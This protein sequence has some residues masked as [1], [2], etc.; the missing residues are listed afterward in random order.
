MELRDR[1]LRNIRA[2]RCGSKTSLSISSYLPELRHFD[3][4]IENASPTSAEFLFADHSPRSVREMLSIPDTGQIRILLAREAVSPDF[5][6]FDYAISFDSS[7]ESGRH[8]RPH[9]LLTFATDARLLATRR[10]RHESVNSFATRVGFCDFI[11]G[12]SRAHPM[13]E[14][15]L[16][17]L[18]RRFSGVETMRK[19]KGRNW[20]AKKRDSA[21]VPSPNWRVEK[22]SLQENF[23][24]SIAAENAVFP[25]YTT[26]KLL[27]PISAGS[28]PIYWGNPLV[29]EEFN[30][31]RFIQFQG[32]NFDE[33]EEEIL[34]IYQNE[35]AWFEMVSQ[36]VLTQEQESH[37]EKNRSQ[38]ID[39][40]AQFF[41]AKP[42]E[43]RV[44]P[45]GWYPDWYTSVIKSGYLAQLVSPSRI[46]GAVRTLTGSGRS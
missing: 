23:L 20:Y 11:Y 9:T 18:S 26:E 36:P 15:M 14:R 37:L 16:V 8:F 34:K 22:I 13:R 27:H 19:Y 21:L 28:I 35:D 5:N 17:E 1:T 45:R 43:L 29:S 39:W 41:R 42:Q 30:P 24:F 46:R 40:F 33:L 25:G 7:I 38:M 2:Y 32:N 6:L 31:D 10:N 12:N 3:Y 44:R 4:L